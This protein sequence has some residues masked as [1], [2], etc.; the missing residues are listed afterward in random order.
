[1]CSSTQPHTVDRTNVTNQETDDLHGRRSAEG[2]R[3][4]LIGAKEAEESAPCESSVVQDGQKDEQS[5]SGHK[6][7][8]RFDEHRVFLV[9]DLIHGDLL[10]SCILHTVMSLIACT[11]CQS[12]PPQCSF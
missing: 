1:M 2:V 9:V 4:H 7:L 12:T 3:I 10:G 6:H 8:R 5:A 11:L